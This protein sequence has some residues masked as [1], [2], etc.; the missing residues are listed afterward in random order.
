M[1]MTGGTHVDS[2]VREAG[3]DCRAFFFGI[4]E[5]DR[6]FLD[7]GHRNVPAIIAG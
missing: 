6:E 7:R 2:L 1:T 3:G 4:A 5:E